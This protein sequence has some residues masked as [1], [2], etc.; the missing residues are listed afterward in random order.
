[1]PAVDLLNFNKPN[2]TKPNHGKKNPAWDIVS[3]QLVENY[4]HFMEL[5]GSVPHTQEPATFP[6]SKPNEFVPI[7]SLSDRFNIILPSI[8]WS[9]KYLCIWFSRQNRVCI[10]LHTFHTHLS[11]LDFTAPIYGSEYKP[12]SSSVCNLPQTRYSHYP[13]TEQHTLFG[14]ENMLVT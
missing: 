4:P 9:S 8:S 1:M 6:Y 12:W 10:P 5:E 13:G 7:I 11:L 3:P 2:Q 14:K